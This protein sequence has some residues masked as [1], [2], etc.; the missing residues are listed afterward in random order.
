M[1]RDEFDRALMTTPFS[2]R[3]LRLHD[4]EQRRVIEQQAQQIT[5]L[6]EALEW[7]GLKVSDENVQWA[8]TE[9]GPVGTRA[10]SYVKAVV[11]FAIHMRRKAQQAIKEVKP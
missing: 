2:N 3:E 10:E 4:A 7:D 11:E 6:R 9:L 8:L 5:T 1:T